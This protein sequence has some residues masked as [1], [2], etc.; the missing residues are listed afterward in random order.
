MGNA[1]VVI[2]SHSRQ[3][4]AGL[5]ELAAQMAG[6][7]VHL[8]AVGGIGDELG[9]S[10]PAIAEA[11]RGCPV[12]SPIL[13]FFDIGSAFM[14]CELALELVPENVRQRTTLVDAP[15]VEGCIEAA[16]AASLGQT[17]REVITA[18]QKARTM[19][20]VAR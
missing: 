5:V 4:A 11:L 2:V 9:T 14:N 6:P 10:A 1:S 15:L 3:L 20:K 8:A 7:S 12:N 17:D 13:V 16:V 19:L 18:A